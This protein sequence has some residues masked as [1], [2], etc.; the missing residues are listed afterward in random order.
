MSVREAVYCWFN[1]EDRSR[2]ATGKFRRSF[3]IT[4]DVQE[5]YLHIYAD[6]VYQLFVNGSFIEFGPVR[7]D[8]RYPLYDSIDLKPH[9]QQGANVIALYVNYFGCKT[10]KAMPQQAGFI[11]WGSIRHAA[12]DID[13]HSSPELWR[14][15]AAA[16]HSRYTRKLSFA[17][18]TAEHVDQVNGDHG[19]Q[20][21]DYDD[22]T[23]PTVTA[24]TTQDSW[25]ELQ[26]RSIPFMS[27]ESLPLRKLAQLA[28]LD[29]RE[30]LFSFTV[31]NPHHFDA[32]D[33][34][35]NRY[36]NF[37]ALRTYIY[38]PEDMTV[39]V[40]TFWGEHWLNGEALS[41]GSN[42]AVKSMR[43]NQI[44]Q[45]NK[46][47]N[48]FFGKVGMYADIYNFYLGVPRDA[49]IH[50]SAR[51]DL[52]AAPDFEHSPVML[53]DDYEQHLADKSLPYAE[54]E[55]LD[56]IGGW[57]LAGPEQA[58]QDPGH[59][60]SWDDFGNTMDQISVDEL[61]GFT[62][63]KDKYPDG[64]TL[65]L[66]Q[67]FMHLVFPE[68]TLSG[69]KGATIDLLYSEHL[70]A[71]NERL[72]INH[73]YCG[74]D[75]VVCSEDRIDWRPIQP[76]GLRYLRITVRD[77]TAD[78]ILERLNVRSAHYPVEHKGFFE[79]SDPLLMRIWEMGRLTQACNMEDAYVDCSGRERGMYGRDTIIQY[80][81]ALAAFG[82]QQLMAR[83][84][85]LYGQSPDETRKF[86]AVYPNT[87]DYT[88]ADFA[89]NMVEG[90]K[91]YYD[92]SGDTQRI[93]DDWSAIKAN[94]EWF[95]EL[96]DER[97][98]LLLDGEW[99]KHHGIKAHYGGF[100]GDNGTWKGYQDFTGVH[101]NFTFT[102]I[103]A[104][105]AARA[106]ADLCGDQDEYRRLGKRLDSIRPAC[107]Q[108]WDD[109]Q[110]CF[111]DNLDKHCHSIQANSFAI[112]AGVC[113]DEQYELVRQHLRR[114]L[115]HVFKNGFDAS[116]GS[117]MSP[118]FS[119]YIFDG[120]YKAG[121]ADVAE[122]AFRE[123]WGWFLTQGCQ[124]APEFFRL[125][126][127]LCHAWSACPTYYLSRY[128]VGIFFDA[129][130]NFKT[131]TLDPQAGPDLDYA[132]GIFPHPLGK[133]E[134]K[135]TRRDN[136]RIV[137]DFILVPAGCDVIFSVPEQS[138][139]IKI[140][141]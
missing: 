116:E 32:K 126:A 134:A 111:S 136:G 140:L 79:C 90:Y 141:S 46:G 4:G 57:Q 23:W 13:L 125:T 82:D 93:M 122:D 51:K 35:L 33:G 120:L 71:D 43:I 36:S 108:F 81:N 85:Q 38:A 44:W 132:H 103:M 17:L 101:A 89:L 75:R 127:S 86:R 69:V 106:L 66:D 138:G 74:A 99:D 48:Y 68:I 118:A 110:Q 55:T 119:F 27:G 8:P 24:L 115:R 63:S 123:G 15:K 40:G 30:Q 87:G 1:D 88:I 41:G 28:P 131:I 6:T 97:D 113:S 76:R 56:A 54:D 104:M 102:Y 80:H 129:S 3:T 25:G 105:E 107:Q 39:P 114:E 34:G 109:R 61:Q 29:K 121:L 96:A 78:V 83:C 92:Y 84:M 21:A 112:R 16:E 47:W 77:T 53:K 135:W 26:P 2:N 124:T 58:A 50:V 37:L 73:N 65:R 94:M 7:N 117:N 42:D 9:L 133:V 64:F 59:E 100:H 70:N 20:Q 12:D 137:Y 91:H 72:R 95:H 139:T 52:D 14:G 60:T 98:D 10:F 22:S 49:G 31:P 5:A 19:W 67:E 18:D 11:S 62:F 45:L 130:S 128:C